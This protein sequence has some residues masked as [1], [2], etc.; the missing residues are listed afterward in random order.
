[1][2]DYLSDRFRAENTVPVVFIG[3]AAAAVLA[4]REWVHVKKFDFRI[5]HKTTGEE[6][7]LMDLE[8]SKHCT[9][10]PG[11]DKSR[12]GVTINSIYLADLV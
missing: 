5:V 12:S 2:Y 9:K 6:S 11:G 4:S 8:R 7:L 10:M 3:S 1:M